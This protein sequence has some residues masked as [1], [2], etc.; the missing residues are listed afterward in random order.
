MVTIER[1]LIKQK[2]KQVEEISQRISG[3]R[4]AIVSDYR[5][6]SVPEM[7]DFRTQINASG[8]KA[9]VYKNTLIRFAFDSL[10]IEY[11][12][13]LLKG[14]SLLITTDFDAVKVSKI[15]VNFIKECDKLAIKGGVLD[16]RH[17]D[18]SMIRVLAKLP[19]RDV[20]VAKTVG[21]IKGPLTGLVCGL[22]SPI[23]GLINV[24]N[25][26]KDK[27]QEV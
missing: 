25:S 11:P 17:V 5:G 26:I 7:T 19:D 24:L 3:S 9:S 14:P 16:Q 10:E 6:L 4:V 13:A 27:K 18:D 21:L 2:K 1:E 20:L 23:S 12:E 8:G 15:V 22:K